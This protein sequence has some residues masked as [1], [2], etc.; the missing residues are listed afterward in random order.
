VAAVSQGGA[1]A[2][3]LDPSVRAAGMGEASN[4]VFWGQDPNYWSNPALLGYHRGF[5]FEH[6]EADLLPDIDVGTKFSSDRITV[7]GWGLGLSLA[8]KPWDSVGGLDLQYGA[9]IATNEVGEVIGVFSPYEDVESWAI[10]LSLAEFTENVLRLFD[11]DFPSVSRYGD[12]SLGYAAKSDFIFLAPSRFLQDARGGK[13]EVD[14]KDR[15]LLLRLTPYNSIDYPGFLPKLDS[16]FDGLG[17]LRFDISHARATQSYQ[18]VAVVFIDRDQADAVAKVTRK[19]LAA[20]LAIGMPPAFRPDSPSKGIRWL[21]DS[22]TPLLSW[23]VAWD[24]NQAHGITPATGEEW[25]EG[26]IK[27]SGWELTVAN[28]FSLRRGH[29]DNPDGRIDDSS[30]GWS[31]GF[32]FIDIAGF[33]YDKAKVP[34][35][36]G[37][38]KVER[39]G[40][41]FFIDGLALAGAI[42]GGFQTPGR[43]RR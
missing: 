35:P 29:V 15:G 6:S 16:L 19:G 5:R 24:N 34:R 9:Q 37:H 12:L 1:L 20:R 10:G 2:F 22:L 43:N 32:R 26:E 8:G 41:S 25:E 40:Y 30:S 33:R 23:G 7:G 18:D 36:E 3:R 28:I 31:L 27:N 17:G 39:E 11:V 42:T 38:E 21:L 14:N 4:A 13:T